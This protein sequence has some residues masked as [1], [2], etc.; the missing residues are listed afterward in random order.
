MLLIKV[1][2]FAHVYIFYLLYQRNYIPPLSW[3]NMGVVAWTYKQILFVSRQREILWCNYFPNASDED[4]SQLVLILQPY[5]SSAQSQYTALQFVFRQAPVTS[6]SSVKQTQQVRFRPSLSWIRS[7]TL[8]L[9]IQQTQCKICSG[10]ATACTTGAFS[11]YM[12]QL[13]VCTRIQ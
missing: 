4:T 3:C 13:C 10:Y 9:I 12:G 7:K 11:N 2:N 8:Q 1:L 6:M 5:Q